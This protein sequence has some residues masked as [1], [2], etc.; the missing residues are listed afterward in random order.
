MILIRTA[1]LFFGVD[2]FIGNDTFTPSPLTRS[3][4]NPTTLVTLQQTLSL[5]VSHRPERHIWPWWSEV[6]ASPPPTYTLHISLTS[7]VALPLL[8]IGIRESYLTL[9]LWPLAV[10]CF[11]D[12][13]IVIN[14]DW[15]SDCLFLLWVM[16]SICCLLVLYILDTCRL[17]VTK[18]TKGALN[19]SQS[20]AARDSICLARPEHL[21][22][23]YSKF[24][25][26]FIVPL[27]GTPD[28]PEILYPD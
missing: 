25:Y 10:S 18:V 21:H 28:P 4:D 5:S 11:S 9:S 13:L 22:A 20:E 26:R 24:L 7:S 27:K 2:S 15:V 1:R 12:W 23:F 3:S 14:S 16:T 8:F 17:Q 19:A 6:V